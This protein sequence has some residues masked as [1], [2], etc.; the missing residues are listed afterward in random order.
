[1]DTAYP[2]LFL[3]APSP[4][5]EG[6][7]FLL[8]SG[9][10][11]QHDEPKNSICARKSIGRHRYFFFHFPGHGHSL[12]DR[13]SLVGRRVTL[14]GKTFRWFPGHAFRPDLG[15]WDVQLQSRFGYYRLECGTTQSLLVLQSRLWQW[16][17][18][19]GTTEWLLLL[20]RPFFLLQN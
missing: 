4:T 9:S 15:A 7:G 16:R 1:M 18:D 20:Q 5:G 6:L 3:A 10:P 2:I 11:S 14:P 12:S 13:T 17:V 19:L 8:L